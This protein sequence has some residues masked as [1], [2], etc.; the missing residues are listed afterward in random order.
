MN[1]FEKSFN[2]GK[3]GDYFEEVY[4]MAIKTL[5]QSGN[6]ENIFIFISYSNNAYTIDIAD[7]DPAGVSNKEFFEEYILDYATQRLVNMIIERGGA[8]GEAI[9]NWCESL[10]LKLNDG[11]LTLNKDSRSEW[12]ENGGFKLWRKRALC[13]DERI[14]VTEE[15]RDAI[16]NEARKIDGWSESPERTPILYV[17]YN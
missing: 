2:N 9:N 1:V 17:P 13:E 10:G 7:T 15:E 8:N 12:W 3:T 14:R 4:V 11:Y 5:P 6:R 16:L